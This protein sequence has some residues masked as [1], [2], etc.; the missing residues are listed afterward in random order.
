MAEQKD[1]SSKRVLCGVLAIV[2]PIL[3][4]HRFMLGDPLGGIL[5][6]LLVSCGVGIVISFV[7]GLIYITKSDADF[8]RIYVVGKKKWF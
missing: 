7:E 3:A 6:I 2:V 8:D 5:R 1:V 4:V